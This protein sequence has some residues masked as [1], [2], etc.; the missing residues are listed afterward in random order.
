[1]YP[2][3]QFAS[4]FWDEYRFPSL[5]IDPAVMGG[6]RTAMTICEVWDKQHI[7][8]FD[9]PIFITG[10]QQGRSRESAERVLR[11]IRRARRQSERGQEPARCPVVWLYIEPHPTSRHHELASFQGKRVV[12]PRGQFRTG[13]L[14]A[15]LPEGSA[16]PDEL[17]RRLGR[18]DRLSG[19]GT[20]RGPDRNRVR[21]ERIKG[22]VSHGLLVPSYGREHWPGDVFRTVPSAANPMAFNLYEF[23][24]AANRLGVSPPPAN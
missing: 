5:R 3:P 1:M 13:E 9:M 4:S 23:D 7:P 8:V 14:A 17:L 24:C 18:W 15:F 19:Y 16:L 21:M 22:V 10:R 11:S 6:E 2:F 12:V 20:L